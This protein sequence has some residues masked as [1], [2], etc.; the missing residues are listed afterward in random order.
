MNERLRVL[1][2]ARYPA[3]RAGLRE[4]LAE[5]GF[6]VAGELGANESV[7]P[8][9][10]ADVLVADLSGR[11]AGEEEELSLLDEL[12]VELPTVYLADGPSAVAFGAEGDHARGWL[13]RDV[14]GARLAA[15]VRAVAT[16]MLV[17]DSSFAHAG[18]SPGA[19]AFD[20]EQVRGAHAPPARLTDR[21]LDVLRLVAAGLPNKGIALALGISDHTVKFHLG[22][23]LGKLDAH[24]RTEAVTLAVRAGMLAL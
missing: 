11:P 9:A 7:A 19:S 8:L 14:D 22:S 23:V 4:L 20:V 10:G 1:V 18:G 3:V 13:P 5:A 21:E 12:S 6:D 24:S 15:A 16:G 2:Y 17:L